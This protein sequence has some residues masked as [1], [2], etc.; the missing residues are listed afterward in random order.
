[1]KLIGLGLAATAALASADEGKKLWKDMNEFERL[2]AKLKQAGVEPGMAGAVT[3]EQIQPKR[4]KSNNLK[5]PSKSAMM[6]YLKEAIQMQT[7]QEVTQVGKFVKNEPSRYAQTCGGTYGFANN[8]GVKQKQRDS[9]E[10]QHGYNAFEDMNMS[11]GAEQSFYRKR[12]DLADDIKE[13][14][15]GGPTR[16]FGG[17]KMVIE[18]APWQAYFHISDKLTDPDEIAAWEEANPVDQDSIDFAV[19]LKEE[20]EAMEEEDEE[21]A[22]LVKD[23]MGAVE[24]ERIPRANYVCGASIISSAYILTAAHCTEKATDVENSG[25]IMGMTEIDIKDGSIDIDPRNWR[26]IYECIEHPGWNR[27]TLQDDIALVKMKYT[28]DFNRQR[29]PI[30]L[31]TKNECLKDGHMLRVSG[32]GKTEDFGD[33]WEKYNTLSVDEDGYM[34]EKEHLRAVDVPITKLNDCIWQYSNTEFDAKHGVV[35]RKTYITNKNICAGGKE[36]KDACHGDSG[37]PLSYEDR[38]GFHTLVGVVSWG[39]HCGKKNFP[40]V[41][42]RVAGYLDWIADQSN[43]KVQVQDPANYTKWYDDG[44]KF[45]KCFDTQYRGAR[46]FLEGLKSP[47]DKNDVA[48]SYVPQVRPDRAMVQNGNNHITADFVDFPTSLDEY[49]EE[50]GKYAGAAYGLRDYFCAMKGNVH[51]PIGPMSGIKTGDCRNADVG[52][53]WRLNR[54]KN[55]IESVNY[56]AGSRAQFCWVA[57][58]YSHK[59]FSVGR[60]E[61][62]FMTSEICKTNNKEETEE[63]KMQEE[64]IYGKKYREFKYDVHTNQIWINLPGREWDAERLAIGYNMW[65]SDKLIL[66]KPNYYQ[67][68]IT[69]YNDENGRRPDSESID[70]EGN[71]HLLP[72]ST[73]HLGQQ[74]SGSGKFKKTGN[75]FW[76]PYRFC[77]QVYDKT[78][79]TKGK[80]KKAKPQT[81]TIKAVRMRACHEIP[82]NER[83]VW[84]WRGDSLATKLTVQVA[85]KRDAA[86]EK[87]YAR[88]NCRGRRKTCMAKKKQWL[89]DRKAFFA[90]DV[91]T[92]DVTIDHCLSF[93]HN[94]FSGK[95]QNGAIVA[96]PCIRPPSKN[97]DK[98]FKNAFNAQRMKF[99]NRR[100]IIRN[101]KPG[102]HDMSDGNI[103]CIHPKLKF[104]EDCSADD[105]NMM[106]SFTDLY[107]SKCT[108]AFS[109]NSYDSHHQ[110]QGAENNFRQFGW[111]DLMNGW[112]Y[113]EAKLKGAECKKKMTDQRAALGL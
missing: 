88:F 78:Y 91:G 4:I 48:P 67:W 61:N 85:N 52:A 64:M 93:K 38:N 98:E 15:E 6:A 92:R 89:V 104:D 31:P 77:A 72:Q 60:K 18:N 112:E 97:A 28:I 100:N 59:A 16:V 19:A 87:K 14:E 10:A 26:P 30:C 32:W 21:L 113:K 49:Y 45:G 35:R 105:R 58:D 2:Q 65:R 44:F 96:K 1:M 54:N 20:L 23:M 42:T 109:W 25:V 50:L 86:E 11:E 71:L 12:R 83:N 75:D 80:G 94:Y 57:Q 7:V 106:Y 39:D 99:D 36:G 68:G 8:L 24:A 41:Y 74:K 29:A 13:A 9:L 56:E 90:Q 17:D 79:T 63:E 101:G 102:P 82:D 111:E 47:T 22:E 55:R 46:E 81:V 27:K 37:G 34:T 110:H 3:E 40:T 108:Y 62:F 70:P 73:Y 95:L 69:K 76:Y 107:G 53:E 43:V 51:L 103:F 66:D 5:P 84:F 33:Q